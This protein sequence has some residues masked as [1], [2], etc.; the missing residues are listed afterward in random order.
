MPTRGH[1]TKHTYFSKGQKALSK[2]GKF[3]RQ[4]VVQDRKIGV[5]Y[6]KNRCDSVNNAGTACCSVQSPQMR[7][8]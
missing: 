1:V 6:T 7:V 3:G 5:M 8:V 4:S 2:K